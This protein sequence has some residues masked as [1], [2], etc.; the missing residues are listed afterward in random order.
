MEAELAMCLASFYRVPRND[1]LQLL[2]RPRD[3]KPMGQDHRLGSSQVHDPNNHRRTRELQ[4]HQFVPPF[5]GN[6]SS[7]RSKLPLR[8]PY[9]DRL[10]MNDNRRTLFVSC[11]SS[12][13]KRFITDDIS[14]QYFFMFERGYPANEFGISNEI[15][16]SGSHSYRIL[17]YRKHF[18]LASNHQGI[19]CT[20]GK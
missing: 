1:I 7:S 11:L 9:Q 20:Y 6:H 12:G 18:L 8:S 4:L 13:R 17:Q 19:T 10:R 16:N 14:T 3:S 15:Y 5:F 2:G